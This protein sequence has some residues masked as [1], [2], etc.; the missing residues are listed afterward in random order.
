MSNVK[1]LKGKGG[2]GGPLIIQVKDKKNKILSITGGEIHPIAVK[3]AELT[4]GEAVNGF[5]A[6]YPEDEIAC[7]VIDCGGTM[8]CGLY[9][10]KGILTINVNPS[11]P[12]GP[13]AKFIT[14]A[15]YVSGVKEE[16]I[17]LTNANSVQTQIKKVDKADDIKQIERKEK[18]KGIKEFIIRIGEVVGKFVGVLYQSGR[19]SVDLTIKNILPF[20]AFVAA[21]SGI[22]LFTGLGNA[23][24]NVVTPLSNSPLGLIALSIVLTIPILS[25]LLGPGSVIAQVLS[26]LIGTQIAA[27]TIPPQFALP[28]LFGINAQVGADFIP[29][30]LSLMEAKTKT[31]KVGVPAVLISR[32]ITGPIAVAVAYMFSIGMY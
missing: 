29:V 11:G 26:V 5:T 24:A 31:V 8:R 4:G 22:I 9:P 20:M 21:L 19:D 30:G 17:N 18:K 7:V 3:I 15:L 6:V 14:E 32:M 12:S 28:A 25:P 10:Q 13:M 27:G 23:V 2:W 16:C 1:I